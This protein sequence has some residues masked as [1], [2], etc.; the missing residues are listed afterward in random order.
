MSVKSC[1]KCGA[2]SLRYVGVKGFCKAHYADAVAAMK[3]Q[4]S[5]KAV[6]REWIAREH[7]A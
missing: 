4:G 6:G 5:G 2:V 3:A 1:C 7:S